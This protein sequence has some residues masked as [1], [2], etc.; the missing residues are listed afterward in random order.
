MHPV[1]GTSRIT[2]ERTEVAQVPNF[3]TGDF[4]VVR[5]AAIKED[6]HMKVV[7]VSVSVLPYYLYIMDRTVT[8]TQTGSW[9]LL[10]ARN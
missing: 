8:S 6:K 2:R 4:V 1:D 9:Q 10:V 7:I 3:P 5:N